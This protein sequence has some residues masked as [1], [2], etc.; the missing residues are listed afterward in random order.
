MTGY[1]IGVGNT[2]YAKRVDRPVETLAAEATIAAAADAGID[3]REIDG[4]IA[5]AGHVSAET[6]IAT[7][8]LP[9]VR[10]R[11]VSSVGGASA[12]S[13][14]GSAAV[15]VAGGAAKYVLMYRALKGNSGPRKHKRPS[16]VP[17][18]SIRQHLEYTAGWNTAAQRYSMLARRFMYEH[19][20]TRDHLAEVALAARAHANLNPGAQMYGRELTKEKYLSGRV[21]ADPYRL[22]DCCLETDGACAVIVAA[23]PGGDGRGVRILAAAEGAP[24]VPD[25]LVSRP[26]FL[27]IGLSKAA[28]R[29]W[30]E[31]G[32]GPSDMDAAMIY[33]CFT[34]EVVHQL[35]SAG[36]ATA[37]GVGD[38]IAR[39]DIRLGGRLPVNTHGGLLSE[40]HL[41]G[42]NHILEAVRQL[43]GEAG[44]RQVQG[45]RHIAVTGW[46]NLGDG[47]L[48]V[49]GGPRG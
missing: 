4:I 41:V 27:Q 17:G 38:M 31:A 21:I 23:D 36:F 8:G 37:D 40:G 30:A 32:L 34:F 24:D 48:A 6:L 12:V 49:L 3:V 43:R 15:A 16:F 10:F 44:A 33:D 5:Y 46:G 20:L 18:A 45:A 13:A 1:L 47:S 22:Y 19:D 2:E 42:L 14:L 35:E 39:G 11:A 29:A 26:D 9:D 7:L 25:D 28:P